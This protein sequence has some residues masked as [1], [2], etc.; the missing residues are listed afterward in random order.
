MLEFT[1]AIPEII[2]LAMAGFMIGMCIIA[3][4]KA[5]NM[6][7]EMWYNDLIDSDDEE[8]EEDENEEV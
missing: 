5:I 2:S 6:F 7:L 4:V 1:S 8:E 3:S